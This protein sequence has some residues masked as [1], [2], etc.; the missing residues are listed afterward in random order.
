MFDELST[1]ERL[2]DPQLAFKTHILPIID[3]ALFQLQ[4]QF[5]GQ[6]FVSNSFTFLYPVS[7]LQL[8]D[9]DLNSAAQKF[10]E[11]FSRRSF[12]SINKFA[13]IAL[14]HILAEINSPYPYVTL[15]HIF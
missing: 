1:D 15:C 13:A 12:I 14:F 4:N 10:Q 2:Q 3:I 9:S 6:Q 8:S 7:V 5:E 11:T